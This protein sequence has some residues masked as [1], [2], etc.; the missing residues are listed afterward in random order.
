MGPP[1]RRASRNYEF[2]PAVGSHVHVKQ[3]NA[4]YVLQEPGVIFDVETG[5]LTDIYFNQDT[6]NSGSN[7]A[8]QRTRT[9]CDWNYALV[10]SFP[11]GLIGGRLSAVFAQQLLAS[12]RSV[13]MQFFMG[14]PE[15]WEDLY[16]AGAARSFIGRRSLLSSVVQRTENKGKSVVGLNIVGEGSSLLRAGYGDTQ[17]HP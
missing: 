9:G 3:Y 1:Y 17:V 14:D 13:W 2:T 7:G 12:S 8:L 15:Y 11:A 5:I 10:M 6:T 4:A 16:G